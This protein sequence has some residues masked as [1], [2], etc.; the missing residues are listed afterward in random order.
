MQELNKRTWSLTT[1]HVLD[2][3][4]VRKPSAIVFVPNWGIN[5]PSSFDLILLFQIY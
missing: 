4:P 1:G 5:F 3:N 2:P